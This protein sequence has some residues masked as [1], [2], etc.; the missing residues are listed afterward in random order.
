MGITRTIM[1]VAT[2]VIVSPAA[3]AGKCSQCPQCGEKVCKVRWEPTTVDKHC[4]EVEC[5][6]VCI[7]RFRWPWQMCC[8]PKCGRVKTVNVMKKVDYTCK[9]C[10]C[11]WEVT[12]VG[13]GCGGAHGCAKRSCG[14]TPKGI[15]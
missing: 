11:V 15:R 8:D 13:K 7:P 1:V 4:Y 2:V 12:C 3:S 5:K 14:K 6:D 10:G 9:S